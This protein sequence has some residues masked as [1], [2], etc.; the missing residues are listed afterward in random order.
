MAKKELGLYKLAKYT[1]LE[2]VME[3]QV[4]SSGANQAKLLEKYKKNKASI[5]QQAIAT[6]IIFAAMLFFVGFLP[7]SAYSQVVY[8]FSIPIVPPESVLIPG[9]ILFGANFIM[10]MIYLTML[11]MFAISAMMS[12]DAFRWYETLPIPKDK[13]RKLGFMTVFHNMDIGIIVMILAFPV[14]MFI[15]SQNIFLA[16]VA[17]LISIIN[18]MFSFSVLVL[19]AGRISRVLKVSEAASKKATLIRL[20]TMLS[21][22]IVIF[23]ASFFVQWILTSAGDFFVSLYSSEIPNFVN[24]ILCLIPFP[25]ASGYLIT[26]AIEPTS[27]SFSLWL[28][29]IIGMVL[30]VLLT[31]STYKKA[32]KAMRTVTS[33]ASIEI[34][35]AKSSKKTPEKPIEVTIEL[36]TPIKAYI[37]KDLSTATRDIQAFMFIITPIIL[38]LMVI[39][40]LLITPIG[41]GESFIDDYVFMWLIITM[42]QP[43]I[44]MML[45][46]GF[47]N[48]EDTGA[49]TLSSLP[50]RTRDQ[51]KAKLLLLGS[52]QTISFFLP[53]MFFTGNPDFISYL[54][55]F[56]SFYPVILTLLISM[57][58]MKIRFFGR[59]KYKFVVEEFNIEKKI[60]KWTIMIIAEHLIFFAFFLMGVILFASIGPVAMFI[61]Y[62]LGG[63]LSLGVLLLSFNSMFPKVL[64]K[65]KTISIREIYRKHPLFGTVNLL[66]LYAG[67]LILPGL[68][69]G[70]II[71]P[72]IFLS[73]DITFITLLFIDFFVTFGVMALLWLLL[74]PRSLGLPN[75]K[76]TLKEY[77]KTIGLKPDRKIGR[78]I[79]LGV[80]CSIIY[81][82]STYITGNI[83]GNY[84]FD[85]DVIFGNPGTSI[86]IFGWFL[87]ILMLIP[88]IWEEVSFRGV[89]STLNLRKYSQ[90]TVLVVVALLFGFFHLFNLLS[91]SNLVLTG[92]QVIYASLMGFLFGYLFIKTK[93]LIPSIILHYLINSLGQL[94]TYVVF[95]NTFEGTVK[96]VLFAIVGVGIIPSVLGMLLVKIVVK[97][98][99]RGS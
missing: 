91:G 52:I 95:D 70:L 74:V 46:S 11:G 83:F 56:I 4:L 64:G 86:S 66:V 43:M 30:F 18:V 67:F 71:F 39:S 58:Q 25:F 33:S 9:S 45:T 53:L 48:M 36:R 2:I 44:S 51:A 82:V 84:I 31:L 73:A 41:L 21:Y 7:V 76:E 96:L 28:P 34:E 68:I 12:G 90:R 57:F 10:Q 81:F 87:F 26:M 59:M 55:S 75:G 24:I 37:R 17:A 3:A 49:S 23:S 15:M 88:G 8:S 77:I 22:I 93:S 79:F 19:V 38:P 99:P 92:V 14:T 85:L 35:Q 62:F 61:A 6:K 13:L 32:L 20:F 69:E 63:I 94:F 80:S 65:K 78:N 29:V 50:I 97:K 98:E 89:I 60:T 54:L 42:Y 47:L 5:K 1:N 72:L 40:P 16:L 27:F